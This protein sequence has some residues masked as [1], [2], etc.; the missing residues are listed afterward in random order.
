[1]SCT[2]IVKEEVLNSEPIDNEEFYSELLGIFLSKAS[3]KNEGIIYK[4]ENYN[5]AK[6]IYNNIKKY[7]KI[8]P[9]ISYIKSK[10]FKE[11]EEYILEITNDLKNYPNFINNLIK[12]KDFKYIN[13]EKISSRIIRGYF[14]A[15]SYIKDPNNAYSLDFFVD[16][17]DA[18]TFIY[19][20]IKKLGKKV[21]ITTKKNKHIV[22]I[23]NKE[24]IFDI[25][26][27]IKAINSF[28]Y[29]QNIA[30]EKEMKNNIIRSN[31]YEIA[32][33]EK[34]I[35][36]SLRTLK[37]IEE[38]EEK[39]GIE[40]IPETLKE[41]CKY[42]KLNPDMSYLELSKEMGLTKSGVIS[43]AKR[44]EKLYNKFINN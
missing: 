38:I 32:N 15:S 13:N 18:A 21:S 40:N 2:N 1:M 24:C 14:L 4:T 23:R 41:F 8:N 7:A 10:R 22:Y 27:I 33:D 20:F 16:N 36:T 5:L 37:I 42:R 39:V 28:Y 25:L 6:Y 44:L 30:I 29:F 34:I 43:R 12:Y 26:V 3:I 11:H 17:E 35:K 19:L 31:N 9:K